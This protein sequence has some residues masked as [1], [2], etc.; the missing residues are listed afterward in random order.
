MGQYTELVTSLQ[1]KFEE[2]RKKLEDKNIIILGRLTSEIDKYIF[3]DQI[4]DYEGRLKLFIYNNIDV[5]KLKLSQT[6]GKI[7]LSFDFVEDETIVL[8]EF[9]KS[10]GEKGDFKK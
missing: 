1:D 3:M 2:V 7:K 9:H 5:S 8:N 6:D 10:L 4:E